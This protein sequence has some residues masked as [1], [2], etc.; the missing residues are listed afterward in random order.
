MA[1]KID[2][3]ELK[4]VRDAEDTLSSSLRYLLKQYSMDLPANNGPVWQPSPEERAK[5]LKLIRDKKYCSYLELIHSI[6]K[7]E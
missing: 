1:K 5:L 3:E 6:L 2:Y 7:S 4:A